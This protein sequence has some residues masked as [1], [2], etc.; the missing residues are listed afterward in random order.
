MLERFRSW[1]ADAGLRVDEVDIV[2]HVEARGVE[3]CDALLADLAAKGYR[4]L[5]R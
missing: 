2:V 4:I 1:Y 5:D 3:H